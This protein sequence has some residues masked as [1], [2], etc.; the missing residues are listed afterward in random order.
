M[1]KDLRLKKFLGSRPELSCVPRK[2]DT[3]QD[4]TLMNSNK[5][6]KVH[7]PIRGFF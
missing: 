7:N 6:E 4:R 3:N 5:I 2:I 1:H